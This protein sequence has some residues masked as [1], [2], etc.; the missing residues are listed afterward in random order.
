MSTNE[1]G[2]ASRVDVSRRTFLRGSG[3]AGAGLMLAQLGCN[4]ATALTA[5]NLSNAAAPETAQDIL[6]IFATNESFGVTLV[7]T[8]LDA[9]ARGTYS[10]PLPDKV[11]GVL[12]NVRAQEQYHLDMIKGFGGKPRTLTFY[13]ADPNILLDQAT[14]FADL[15]ELEDAA[16]ASVIASFKTF[17]REKR[18]DLLKANF[19]FAAEEAE[20]RLLAN[21]ALGKRAENDQAFAPTLFPSV[22]QFYEVLKHKG[23]I[24]GSG[25]R[26]TYPGPGAIDSSKVVYTTAGGPLATCTSS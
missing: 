9:A 26:I 18:I 22:A 16:I 10:T 3:A 14:L 23:I 2:I 15:V 8:I 24:D 20:H 1:V 19:Q 25:L 11:L 5:T 6:D 13:L 17:T 7:G 4:A 12:R 21:R